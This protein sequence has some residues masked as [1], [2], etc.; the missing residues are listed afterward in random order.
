MPHTKS[1]HSNTK[2]L[3]CVPA[4]NYPRIKAWANILNSLLLEDQSGQDYQI[5]FFSS[6]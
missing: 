5:V 2:E 4:P 1:L 6:F 3:I